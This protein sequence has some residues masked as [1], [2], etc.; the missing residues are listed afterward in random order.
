MNKDCMYEC[1]DDFWSDDKNAFEECIKYCDE[2]DEEIIAKL[3]ECD[4]R[5]YCEDDEIAGVTPEDDEWCKKNCVCFS[6]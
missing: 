6:D 5:C 1:V 3:Y 4:S 2:V